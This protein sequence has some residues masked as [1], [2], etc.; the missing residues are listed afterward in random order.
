MP[1]FCWNITRATFFAR[2][3]EKSTQPVHRGG[4]Q[5]LDSHFPSHASHNDQHTH[6]HGLHPDRNRHFVFFFSQEKLRMRF[7]TYR[8]G[9]ADICPRKF[10]CLLTPTSDFCEKKSV[11]NLNKRELSFLCSTGGPD[12]NGT[13]KSYGKTADV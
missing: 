13:P 3:R 6:H 5:N 2:L 10:E 12:S 8:R 7:E 11:R 1:C 9:E 4:V